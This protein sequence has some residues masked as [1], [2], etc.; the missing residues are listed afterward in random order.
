ME[1]KILREIINEVLLDNN[2]KINECCSLEEY[3]NSFSVKQLTILAVVY[4]WESSNYVELIKIRNMANKKKSYALN[5]VLE[6]INEIIK[7][8]VKILP[9][10]ILDQL[11]RVTESDGIISYNIYENIYSLNFLIF[12]KR[13]ILGRVH[14]DSKNDIINIYIPDEFKNGIRGALNDKNI[15]RENNKY[16][17]IY[18]FT[19]DCMETYGIL[20][21][22]ELYS[23]CNKFK[24]T[25]NK[26]ELNTILN[27]YLFVDEGFNL[28]EYSDSM[29][30]ANIEFDYDQTIG[31]YDSLTDDLNKKLTLNDINNIGDCKYIHKL[32]SY[33][34]LINWLDNRYNGIKEDHE[35]FDELIVIDYINS[36][37]TS[38]DIANKNF[39]MNI[40]EFLEI[41]IYEKNIVAKMLE[42]IFLEYPKW[43]KRGN[44]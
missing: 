19:L 34:K 38:L 40:D 15:I 44:I 43:S 8:Y 29:L 7:T 3:L 32:K 16:N 42:D 41:D 35:L 25:I 14:F 30:V 9:K 36:A 6:N 12:L 13:N 31:F 26:D 27:S 2:K 1:E 10:Q 28:Y 20:T 33:K 23:L 18:K 4:V 5:Y 17:K 11:K 21:I 39:K 24:F 22:D 37:Q